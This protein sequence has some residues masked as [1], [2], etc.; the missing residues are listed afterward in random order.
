MM[1]KKGFLFTVTVFLILT[2]IL[3][4]ISVWVKA[5]ESSERS[6]SEFYKESTVELT[7]EQ[8]TPAKVDN[9]SNIIM[10]RNLA[11]LDEHSIDSPLRPGGVD[12]N[13]NIRGALFDMLVNGSAGTSYFQGST[14]PNETNSA[15]PI[16]R[17]ARATSTRS[18]TLSTCPWA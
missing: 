13:S 10:T 2:Y 17:S 18:T 16:S 11:R 1:D 8:I 4:S 6:F 5:I 14:V 7:I 15:S 9:V 3:L 12:E